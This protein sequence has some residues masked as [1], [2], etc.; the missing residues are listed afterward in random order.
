M[1]LGGTS[2]SCFPGEGPCQYR[3]DLWRFVAYTAD[4]TVDTLLHAEIIFRCGPEPPEQLVAVAGVA[5]GARPDRADTLQ[6]G[7]IRGFGGW[8]GGAG[9]LALGPRL[10]PCGSGAVSTPGM[11]RTV[12][13]TSTHADDRER[14]DDQQVEQQEKQHMIGQI[15]CADEHL[16]S[17]PIA[18]GSVGVVTNRPLL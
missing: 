2:S 17:T 5:A 16:Q 11:K 1:R 12:K 3:T 6:G 9:Y 8:R 14:W 15:G 10:S 13:P 18:R 7:G 4:I